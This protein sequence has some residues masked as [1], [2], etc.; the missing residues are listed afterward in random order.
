MDPKLKA[1]ISARRS[2]ADAEYE[3]LLP[4]SVLCL[5][6][7]GE[8][9]PVRLTVQMRRDGSSSSPGR[10]SFEATTS[11]P[12]LRKKHAGS[13]KDLEAMLAKRRQACEVD[14]GYDHNHLPPPPHIAPPLPPSQQLHHD[15]GVRVEREHCDVV[16]PPVEVHAEKSC[17]VHGQPKGSDHG[18][19]QHYT[20]L[21]PL[22]KTSR[23]TDTEQEE[24]AHNHTSA[25]QLAAARQIQQRWAGVSTEVQK[26]REAR[27]RAEAERDE[28]R[29]EAER[30]VC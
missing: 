22:S 16:Q 29:K 26:E 17:A 11:P 23:S 10:P 25:V 3:W 20:Y 2:A 21:E 8:R 7:F 27:I 28:A 18:L 4:L 24:A 6:Y 12:N 14:Y 19:P 15:S 30:T 13:D 5:T 1:I 9:R